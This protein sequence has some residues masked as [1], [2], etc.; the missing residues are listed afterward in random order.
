MRNAR[1][2]TT[3]APRKA[4]SQRLGVADVALPVLHLRPAALGRVEGAAGDADDPGDPVVVLEQRDQPGAERAGRAG[5]GDGEVA[6][7]RVLVR[8]VEPPRPLAER[9]RT[10]TSG[11]AH[12]ARLIGRRPRSTSSRAP[13]SWRAVASSPARCGRL[14]RRRARRCRSGGRRFAEVPWRPAPSSARAAGLGLGG[15]GLRGRRLAASA[16]PL[17]V[18]RLR[19]RSGP[20]RPRPWPRPPSRPALLRRQGQQLLDARPDAAGEHVDVGVAV[21]VGVDPEGHRVE[22]GEDPDRAAGAAGDRHV[23]GGGDHPLAQHVE[24]DPRAR[25][26]SSSPPGTTSGRPAGPPARPST[27]ASAR[28]SRPCAMID[29]ASTA[30]IVFLY[31]SIWPRIDASRSTGSGSPTGRSTNT[32]ETWL[33]SAA[34]LVGTADRHR[35]HRADDELLRRQL[36]AGQQQVAEPAGDRGEDDVV[37]RAA[38]RRPDGLELLELA[39]G[40]GPAPVRADRAVERAGGRGDRLL[41][42]RRDGRGDRSC[43]RRRAPWRPAPWC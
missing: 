22:V 34:L 21:E 37:D 4:S 18:G 29:G 33:F 35:H 20:E 23:R 41:G 7:R 36:A 28:R 16:L 17:R 24:R 31:S 40:P 2:T 15:V 5:D 30:C 38:E 39:V 42:Q 19:S 10:P 1:W 6:L 9:A 25:A 43:R 32:A 26:R 14:V 11:G 12:R 27:A 8:L 3:S 13:S